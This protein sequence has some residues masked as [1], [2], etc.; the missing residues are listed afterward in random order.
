M[1]HSGKKNREPHA[2]GSQLT[3]GKYLSIELRQTLFARAQEK[4]VVITRRC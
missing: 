4:H 1:R 3:R 2:S